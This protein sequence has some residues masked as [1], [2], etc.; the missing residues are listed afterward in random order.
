MIP[1]PI[2]TL[3]LL[4][5]SAAAKQCM[6]ISVPVD[7]SART[8]I[9]DLLVPRSNSDA[10]AFI[11]NFTQQGRNYTDIA[12]TGYQNTAGKYQISTQFCVP[13]VNNVS[14]PTLQILTH[15]I[16]FDKT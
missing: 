14:T 5:S 4:V 3:A 8:A 2:T 1:L 15:G 13:S 7:I 9:F 12:L 6:N 10:T 11:Q 16:G